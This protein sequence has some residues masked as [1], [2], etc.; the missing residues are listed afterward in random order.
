MTD[1][2]YDRPDLYDLAAPDD[3]QMIAFYAKAAGGPG[4]AVLELLA[5]RGGLPC[6]WRAQEPA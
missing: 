4:R 2:L 5:G 6:R 3:A 1:I